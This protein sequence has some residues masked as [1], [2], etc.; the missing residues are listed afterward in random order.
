[1]PSPALVLSFT[2][3]L[4]ACVGPA[5]AAGLLT[6]DDVKNGTLTG[7]D[8]K[9][10]SIGPSDLSR[11]ARAALGGEAGP[12]G[13]KGD[14]GPAG[15]AGAKGDTG[16]AGPAGVPGAAG[17]DPVALWAEV[18]GAPVGSEA[19]TA[20]TPGTTLAHIGAGT[21]V[22]YGLTFTR[23]VTNCAAIVTR[24]SELAKDPDE[25]LSSAD[26]EAG[27]SAYTYLDAAG[28]SKL[29]WVRLLDAT[30]VGVTGSFSV[31]LRC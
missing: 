2:A 5:W 17:T 28:N 15:A 26:A 31:A 9:D 3:V 10:G 16:A 25:L 7:K 8:I 14:T 18:D 4:A 1:V 22:V 21:S 12:A 30:G 19:V 6:G 23:D 20:G 24:R 29:L 11:T 27:G 13:A